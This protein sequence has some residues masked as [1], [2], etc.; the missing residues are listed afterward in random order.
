MMISKSEY[1]VFCQT[2][3][4]PQLRFGQAWYNH[5]YLHRH[6]PATVEEHQL[7]ERIY[8]EKDDQKAKSLILKYFIDPEQ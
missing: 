4:P 8:Q 5:F 7:L 3:Y 1:D 6:T 2:P